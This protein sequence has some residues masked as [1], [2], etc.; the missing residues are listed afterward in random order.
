M[1]IKTVLIVAIAIFAM[2]CNPEIG[3]VYKLS[4]TSGIDPFEQQ[5]LTP[6]KVL[7][8]DAGYVKIKYLKTG[9]IKSMP[10]G[11]GSNNIPGSF[12]K[13]YIKCR[14]CDKYGNNSIESE[15]S[16]GIEVL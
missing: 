9:I 10:V 16:K 1:N 2:S 8:V 14:D 13:L 4:S 11:L 12:N 5:S 15:T 7:E 6:V 3:E